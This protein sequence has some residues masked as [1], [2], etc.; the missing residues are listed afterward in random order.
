MILCLL[1]VD[2]NFMLYDEIYHYSLVDGVIGFVRAHPS[3]IRDHEHK[4]IHL[5]P[6]NPPR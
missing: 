5:D 4:R 6:S 3:L 1:V 2:F